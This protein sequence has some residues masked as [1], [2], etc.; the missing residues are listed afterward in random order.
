MPDTA[1]PVRVGKTKKRIVEAALSAFNEQG[2]GHVT[3][4]ELAGRLDMSEGN[5][6]YHYKTKAELLTEIQQEF[7]VRWET[8]SNIGT[9]PDDPIDCYVDWLSGWQSLFES[10]VFMFRD[11]AEYGAHSPELADTLPHLYLET[12]QRLK[13]YYGQMIDNG[14]LSVPEAALDDLVMN[15]IV[16]ARFFLEFQIEAQSGSELAPNTGLVQHLTL[17]KPWLTEQA[18]YRIRNGLLESK[19]K[20]QDD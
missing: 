12:T 6:W 10:Y 13:S 17:L 5:L 1:K 20:G 4:A 15:V 7:I 18:Y 14:S 3:T 19:M 9:D 11:R 2:F 16:I 8:L